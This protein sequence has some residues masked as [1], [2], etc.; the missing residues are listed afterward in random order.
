MLKTPSRNKRRKSAGSPRAV[1]TK[2]VRRWPRQAKCKQEFAFR[3]QCLKTAVVVVGMGMVPCLCWLFLAYN[4]PEFLERILTIVACA[5]GGYG[6]ARRNFKGG[7]G[8][9]L[10]PS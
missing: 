10:D 5:A 2:A 7:G 1:P 6:W 8:R 3:A 4:R 9:L